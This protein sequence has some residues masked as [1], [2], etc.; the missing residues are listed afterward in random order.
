MPD[1]LYVVFLL[2]L[3]GIIPPGGFIGKFMLSSTAIES[4]FTWLTVIAILNSVLS[5]A[6]YRRIVVVMYQ[7][8]S[9]T[10]EATFASVLPSS[11]RSLNV[12][13]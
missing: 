12:S 13:L 11:T 2:S 6:V 3:V 7:Q 4:G 8:L 9:D 5:L 10:T 1:H